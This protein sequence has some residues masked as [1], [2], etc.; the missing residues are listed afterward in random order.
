MCLRACHGDGVKQQGATVIL[1]AHNVAHVSVKSMRLDTNN[2]SNKSDAESQ[3]QTDVQISATR[4]DQ[5]S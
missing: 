5:E 1:D 3:F 2:N 4:Q